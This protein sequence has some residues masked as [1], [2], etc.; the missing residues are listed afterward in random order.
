MFLMQV[1]EVM[2]FF[3]FDYKDSK[4]DDCKKGKI[5]DLLMIKGH[6]KKHGKCGRV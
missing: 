4:K 1:F 5:I 6:K 2:R 3:K